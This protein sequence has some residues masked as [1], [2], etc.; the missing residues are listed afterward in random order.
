MFVTVDRESCAATGGCA[1]LCPD[2]FS[3]GA[4]GIVVGG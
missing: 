3:I 4:D 2:V 1:Q